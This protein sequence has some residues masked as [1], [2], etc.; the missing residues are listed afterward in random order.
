MDLRQMEYFL[1]VVDHGGVNRAA[2][3]LRVAQ[4][5]LSQA[6]RKLEKD[7]GSELFHRVGR[8]LVLAPAGEALIG[9]ARM[10]LREAEAAENAV[11]S[12]GQGRSG[13]IDIAALSD[14]STDPLSVWAAGFRAKFPE[15]RFRIEER[16]EAADLVQLVRS[17][18]CEV[19]F[20]AMPIAGEELVSEELVDQKFVLVCPPGTESFWPDPTPVE[21]LSGVPFVMGEH[22]TATREYIENSLREHG[23]E[24][25]IV[26]EVPQR[27]A[28]LPM[29]LSGAGAAI[30]P[31]RIA[32]DA[33]HRGGVVRE[34]S[35]GLSRRVGMMYRRGRM[36]VATSDFLDYSKR[37]MRAWLRSIDRH[38]ARGHSWIEGASLTALTADHRVRERNYRDSE[39]RPSPDR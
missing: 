10:I 30:I 15:V 8:G 21:S 9:P 18:A 34:L 12:V 5:S 24:P 1:A 16:D 13:R 39:V 26:V 2:V 33:R 38:T 17:G 11:R 31:L 23:V 20:S 6:V 35:P 19:G 22:G 28:V 7:L 29:V 25:R 37:S 27:G 3:A 32:L 36:T 14:I 4:P